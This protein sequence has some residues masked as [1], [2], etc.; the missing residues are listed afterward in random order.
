MTGNCNLD[1]N[2][3]GKNMEAV[4]MKKVT[5]WKTKNIAKTLF[6]EKSNETKK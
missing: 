2:K 3:T 1:K 5:E 6:A 4:S